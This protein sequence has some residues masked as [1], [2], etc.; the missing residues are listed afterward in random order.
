MQQE[1]APLWQRERSVC[2]LS[3]GSEYTGMSRVDARQDIAA[4]IASN[5]CNGL[6]GSKKF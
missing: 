1:I 4:T 5:G 3:N 2:T 6:L